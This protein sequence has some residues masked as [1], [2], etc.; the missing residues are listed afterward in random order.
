M[1][2]RLITD[3]SYPKGRS[4]NEAID[5]TACSMAYILVHDVANTAVALGKG[6]L[7]AKIDI[8]AAQDRQ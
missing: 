5:K 3:L 4:A 6:S 7:I 8:K 1:K 2:W